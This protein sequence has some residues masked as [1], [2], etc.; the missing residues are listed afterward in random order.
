[1]TIRVVGVKSRSPGAIRTA[2]MLLSG[3]IILGALYYGQDLAEPLALA[4]LLAFVLA[5]LVRLLERARAPRIV[6][7]LL[8]VLV[9][10]AVIGALSMLV[11]EQVSALIADAPKYQQTIMDKWHKLLENN[12]YFRE[13]AEPLTQS[14][15]FNKDQ[16]LSLVEKYARPVLSPLGTLAIVL[17]FALVMLLDSEDLRDRFVRLLGRSDLH[18]AILAMNDA[19]RRL[20]R[21]FLSLLTINTAFGV[22]IGAMLAL[23]GVPGAILLGL[24]AG[25]MRF[26]PFVGVFVALIPV[27]ALATATSPD[28]WTTIVVVGL[29]L[30][31]E[32]AFGQIL[33]PLIYGHGTGVSPLAVLVATSFWALM[34]GVVGVLIAMPITVCLVTLGKHVP[35]LA[36]LD[37][38]L[39]SGSP[40]MPAET[41]YQRAL[42]RRSLALVPSALTHIKSSSRADYFDRVALPGLCLA[43]AD[44]DPESDDEDAELRLDPVREQVEALLNALAPKSRSEAAAIICLPARGPLDDLGAT[45]L[46]DAL[47]EA[48]FPARAVPNAALDES[49]DEDL[50]NVRICCISAFETSASAPAIHYF[51]GVVS[52]RIPQAKLVI[53]LWGA[54]A[55]SPVL[56]ELRAEAGN[57]HI[58]LSI[59]ELVTYV[60]AVWNPS[61]APAP[62][63]A[64]RLKSGSPKEPFAHV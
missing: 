36:F 37:V 64:K 59:G 18:R 54:E 16:T 56:T 22:W 39:G 49:A 24:I 48:D 50:A 5:P 33:E 41:F 46:A 11:A 13:L 12:R 55:T 32:A 23:L 9:A 53:G 21:Y 52:K 61:S 2:A 38:L 8:A 63:P 3:T 43:Q 1:M 29:F 7:V 14:G 62:K 42:E 35:A 6:A 51:A 40:L 27:V 26:V 28:W 10:F 60:R 57:E 58:I 17:V 34:W 30:L 4:A 19:A 15:N 25:L 47:A 45:M 20:S 44:A 31:T